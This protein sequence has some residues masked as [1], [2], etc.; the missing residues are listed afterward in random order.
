M[1][2]TRQMNKTKD[3][4]I[5]VRT[6]LRELVVYIVFLIV[7]CIRER[8]SPFWVFSIVVGGSSISGGIRVFRFNSTVVREE[9]VHR[10]LSQ[11]F[12]NAIEKY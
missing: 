3:R 9:R 2:A 1:W 8:F 5:Y 6:T 7:L 11:K 4:E 12:F 10:R